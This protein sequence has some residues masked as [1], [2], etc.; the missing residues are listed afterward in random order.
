M[1]IDPLFLLP[2]LVV[3]FG[4]LCAAAVCVIAL[5][6]AHRTDTV[7]VVKALPELAA[8]LLRLCQRP[9]R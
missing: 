9:R 6:R 3:C 8:T 1:S 4:I 2:L 7:A 5:M